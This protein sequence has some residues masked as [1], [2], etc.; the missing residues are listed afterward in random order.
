MARPGVTQA[1]VDSAATAI[2]A[3][4]RVAT[5]DRVR[6][7]IGFG[8]RSTI[9]PM[10]RRWKQARAAAGQGGSP[11]DL[12]APLLDA[13]RGVYEGMRAEVDAA[14]AKASEEARAEV[15]AMQEAMRRLESEK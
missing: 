8:S 5:V 3:A 14:K 2:E 4:G 11:G 9:G 13:V 12:P 15:A 6:E 1:D 7:K 10:L